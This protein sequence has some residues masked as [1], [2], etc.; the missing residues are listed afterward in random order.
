MRA[1]H[2]FQGWNNT[3][4]DT[5]TDI[6][7]KREVTKLFKLEPQGMGTSMVESLSGYI[8]RLASEHCISTGR[9]FM[10]VFTPYLKK[11]YLNKIAEKGG[12][13][14]Y[15]FA[16]MINGNS[17]AA[18]EFSSMLNDLTGNTNL[19]KL[20]ML[21]FAKAIPQ[22]GLLRTVRVWCPRCYEEMKQSDLG[23]VY[24]P[25]IWSIKVITICRKHRDELTELCSVCSKTNLFLDR[26]SSPGV[27]LH[28]NSWLGEAKAIKMDE[29]DHE[30]QNKSKMVEQLLK[31]QQTLMKDEVM[32]SLRHIV[33]HENSN[34]TAV[35]R[36]LS[37]P[38][39]TFW[40]W[41]NGMNLPTLSDVLRICNKC[42]INIVDFY[43]SKLNDGHDPVI[44][45]ER[46]KQCTVKPTTTPLL[47]VK[48]LIKNLVFDSSNGY[49]HVQAMADKVGCNKKTLYNHFPAIC[50]T[51]ANKW[52]QHLNKQ[53]SLRLENV[54]Q[55]I[56]RIFNWAVTQGEYPSIS[57]MEKYMGKPAITREFEI[58]CHYKSM[59]SRKEG[60]DRNC[61][62]R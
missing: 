8:A 4:T 38:K 53:K 44:F 3:D 48:K 50:K 35:A 37:I 28:C 29:S 23:I 57:K 11:H 21:R 41:Y 42:G 10:D 43:S 56:T 31:S 61:S 12:N 62:A 46:K 5:D 2:H 47:E 24:D 13:G 27:C 49:L 36:K 17:N 59:V 14:F 34:I 7:T 18:E 6:Y 54:K 60:K 9:L 51:Q 19:Q 55:N 32:Y 1:Y 15:D 58:K 26:R 33:S 52:R 22:R 25:L 16:H 45:K 40:A 30:S 39:S 20:T